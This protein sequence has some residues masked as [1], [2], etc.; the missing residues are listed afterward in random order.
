MTRGR[1]PANAAM[2][3]R[4]GAVIVGAGSGVRFGS[5]DKVFALLAGK[6]LLQ[7][8]LEWCSSE[9]DIAMTVVVLGEHTIEQG[10]R[11]IDALE[12]ESVKVCP[13]GD[14]RTASVQA[15]TASLDPDVTLV[16]VHDAARPLTDRAL[17][18][19]VMAAA[20]EHGAAIPALPVGDTIHVSEDGTVIESTPDRSRLWSAQ[21]PQVA[22]RDWLEDA[23]ARH[24]QVATDEAGLLCAAGFPVAIVDGDPA[25][26]KITWPRDLVIAEALLASRRESS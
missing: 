11:L 19:R 13:G 7:Y 15:G 2:I 8:A 21:T 5:T 9:P 16:A 10:R 6:P 20:L 23:F 3:H 17:V 14:T 1:S 18:R 12:L 22:R 24:P 25:N 4:T 26:L